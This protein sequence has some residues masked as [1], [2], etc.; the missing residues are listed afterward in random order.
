MLALEIRKQMRVRDKVFLLEEL[1]PTGEKEARI[2][3][4]LQGRYSNHMII[5]PKRGANIQNLETELL[6]FP[7]G[8][9]DDMIDALA[10]AMVISKVSNVAK[11][12]KRV[13]APSWI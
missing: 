6:K 9:H 3:S 11:N 13:S 12:R 5:H 10:S 8:S 7:K 4:A 2:T 1:R